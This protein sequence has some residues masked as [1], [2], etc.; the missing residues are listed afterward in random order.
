MQHLGYDDFVYLWCCLLL[1]LTFFIYHIISQLQGGI[2]KDYFKIIIIKILKMCF[3][4]KII[5]NRQSAHELC[6][7]IYYSR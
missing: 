3:K 1:T 5:S 4:T 7:I 6:M 2:D